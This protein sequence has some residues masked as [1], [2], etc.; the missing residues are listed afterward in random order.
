MAD[1]SNFSALLAQQNDRLLSLH[2]PFEEGPSSPLLVHHFSAVEGVSR[3]FQITLE[4]LSNDA[5]IEL[6]SLMGKM[7]AIELE[8]ADGSSRYFNGHVFEFR[9]SRTDGGYAF[10]H[11]ELGPWTRFLS[12]RHDNYLFQYKTAEAALKEIFEDYGTLADVRFHLHGEYPVE[13]FRTQWDE[14]DY[15][16][17]H[18]RCEEKGWHYWFE[19]GKDGHCLII[20]D[21]ST[22][23]DP[24]DGEKTV[25]FHEAGAVDAEDGITSWSPVRRVVPGK[26]SLS[27]FDFKSP[28]PESTAMSSRNRQGDVNDYEVYE[29]AGAYGFAD[30]GSGTAQA[31]LRMEEIEAAAKSFEGAGNSR[32]LKPGR[33]FELTEHFDQQ[34]DVFDRQFLVLEVRHTASNNYLA[35]DGD[36][37]YANHFIAQRRLVPFRPGRGFNSVQPKIY[38]IQTAIVV[39]PQGEEIHCDQYG[40]VKLKFHWDRS[41]I[42]DDTASCWVR[43]ASTWAGSNFGFMAVPRIG[44]EVIVQW[45][46]GNPDQ[47][48]ITGR[49]YNA[50]NMPPWELPVNKTQTGVLTRSSH[51]GTYDHANAIRF[52]DKKGQEELWLHAEKDQRIEVEHDES[53][54]VGHDRSKTIDHDET[55][56]IKHDRTE[57]VDHDET[58]TNHNHRTERVD[59]DEHISIGDNRT[60]DVGQNETIHIGQNR[61]V[62]I[63]GMK[64]ELITLA[65]TETIGLAKMLSIGA[66]YQTTVGA[67]MNTTVALNQSAQI[68]MDKSTS[69]GKKFSIDAGDEL[70]IQVGKSHFV[71]K[72][73]GTISLS[74]AQISIEASGPVKINGKDVDIN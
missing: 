57:T 30:H 58:I 69:V 73:D 26:F 67:A 3:D 12:H 48:I 22:L 28:R 25:R 47:P 54:W 20:S 17:L 55:S 46:D 70:E 51:G 10:Y 5:H 9:L 31:R 2:Y 40:R 66:A 16:Y 68:G 6:K 38:G 63:G 18:R 53:H 36:A 19:H 61:S 56:H 72:S 32:F 74:G 59:H 8:R 23:A 39:G 21:D 35:N 33:Y 11:M 4:L 42:Q 50:A 49:V 65:K 41:G 24:I 34:G 7:V 27:S 29:Y 43:V 44:Q 1:L 15:N 62:T 71:M 45:L 37:V 13:T 60:E 52:E 14:S 64:N